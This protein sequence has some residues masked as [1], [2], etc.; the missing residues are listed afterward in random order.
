MEDDEIE[1]V[2][3]RPECEHVAL[4]QLHVAQP[5]A[6]QPVARDAQHGRRGLVDAE[7]PPGLRGHELQHPP[8]AGAYIE[9]GP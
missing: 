1:R 3:H 7:N 6:I 4:A 8:G 2:A 9:H 5:R